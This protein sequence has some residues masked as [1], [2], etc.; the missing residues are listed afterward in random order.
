ML[1]L[2]ANDHEI[3]RIAFTPSHGWSVFYDEKGFINQGLPDA[4]HAAVVNAAAK[5]DLTSMSFA[6]DDS[7][8]LI[9]NGGRS[10]EIGNL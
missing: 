4:A 8:C 7:F 3:K 6:G 1:Q 9:Y 10:F 2:A 5:H